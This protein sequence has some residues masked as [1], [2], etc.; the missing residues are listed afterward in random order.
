MFYPGTLTATNGEIPLP[1]SKSITHR[2]I[3]IL[4]AVTKAVT[5]TLYASIKSVCESKRCW[6]IFHDQQGKFIVLY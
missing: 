6:L 2:Q 1:D 4:Q 3:P 5:K